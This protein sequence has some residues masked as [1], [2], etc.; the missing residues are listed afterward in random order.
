MKKIVC[1]ICAIAVLAGCASVDSTKIEG[2]QLNNSS[3]AAHI[4]ANVWGIYLLPTI[5]LFYPSEGKVNIDTGVR[6][7]TR[8]ARSIGATA[9]TDVESDMTSFWIPPT[10][11]LWYKE[12]EVSGNAYK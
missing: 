2:V 8:K 11:V 7:L 9:V 4:N 6:L 10:F 3:N 12:C 5:P 1:A